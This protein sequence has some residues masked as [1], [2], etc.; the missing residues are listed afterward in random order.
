MNTP[1][2]LLGRTLA[3]IV[4][5]DP[6]A[7][8]A[9]QARQ[10]QLTK[11]AG[12]LGLLETT[13]A[14][15]A[16][17]HG[18]C[19]PPFPEHG[20]ATVFCG[21]HGVT[22]AGVSA[23]G[24]ELTAQ[25]AIN[26]CRGGAGINAL[27]AQ[28][29]ITVHVVDVGMATDIDGCP[30]LDRRRV[31]P[32]TDDFTRGPAMSRQDAISAVEVGIQLA[33]EAVAAGADVLIPG[34]V[35]IGNTAVAA[36]V[37]AALTGTDPADT[38]GRGAGATDDQLS[39]KIQVIRAGLDRHQ[40]DRADPIGVLSAIG[41]LEHAA[42][43]GYIL[44]GAAHRVPVLLDGVISASAALL[45]QALSPDSAGYLIAA[46][47]G[48]EP[49]IDTALRHLGLQP[50][51]DLGLRLGEGSGAAV[52]FPLVQASA[53]VLRLMATF[54]DANVTAEHR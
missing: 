28:S 36:A 22:A 13:G 31:R 6:Q 5:T 17:I 10:A 12:S 21:D 1:S 16:A 25:M 29:G 32:G 52:A 23:W 41:G 34:E 9:A 7:L 20:W 51:V 14:Q 49:G 54:A 24:Q 40:P 27:S 4:P 39:H 53:N 35:G 30:E 50:L 33:D 47:A 26:I 46:H 3:A 38:T 18:T 37:F 45:A 15:L 42:I 43:T 19:P 8:A 44:G 48:S 2:D 11:P